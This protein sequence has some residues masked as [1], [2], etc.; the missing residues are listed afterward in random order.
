MTKHH[1]FGL[2]FAI[3]YLGVVGFIDIDRFRHDM[4]VEGVE[5]PLPLPFEIKEAPRIATVSINREFD[6]AYNQYLEKERI[7]KVIALRYR[8][9]DFMAAM[10]VVNLTYENAQR[11]GLKPSMLLAMIATESS[12]N[13]SA[14]SSVGAVGYLQVMPKYHREKIAGR[15][16]WRMD[17]NIQV[18]AQV[19]RDCYKRHRN[20][21]Q[22]LACYNGAVTP[23]K[24]DLY[25]EAVRRNQLQLQRALIASR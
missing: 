18:G 25:Y 6:E 9:I 5:H 4:L 20:E 10:Q 2:L 22:A 1:F 13:R 3:L 21:K 24:A 8:H 7:A 16:I 19:L 14:K 17:V 11:Y 12:F 23:E 15:D